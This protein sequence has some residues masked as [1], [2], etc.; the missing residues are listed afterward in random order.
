VF[1]VWVCRLTVYIKLSDAR[2]EMLLLL[3]LCRLC[4]E[5]LSLS[6]ALLSLLSLDAR[7][8]L[9]WCCIFR[10]SAPSLSGLHAS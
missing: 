9:I 1:G 3:L 10:P 4:D 5:L 2:S 6:Q 7:I 8:V